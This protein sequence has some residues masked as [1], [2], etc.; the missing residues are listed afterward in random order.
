MIILL[1]K[2][3]GGGPVYFGILKRW[4]GSAWVKEPLKRW[5]GSA[6]ANATLKR[7]NGSAWVLVDA[8]GV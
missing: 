8:T 7:W 6:W 2:N 3:D 5:N 1:F 4:D